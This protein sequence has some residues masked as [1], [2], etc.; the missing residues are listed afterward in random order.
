MNR[1]DVLRMAREA[2]ATGYTNRHYPDR[3]H[4]AF[5]PEQLER[6][7]AQVAEHCAA[8]CDARDMGDGTRED[9]E[10]R[11]CAAAIRESIK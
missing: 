6:F 1:D 9:Q 7:A 5:S 8:L 4:N 3:P 2:G 11:R 10:A